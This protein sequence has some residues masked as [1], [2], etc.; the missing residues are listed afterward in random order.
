MSRPLSLGVLRGDPTES[1]TC[2]LWHCERVRQHTDW[3]R[4]YLVGPALKASLDGS[5]TADTLLAALGVV[6]NQAR[7]LQQIVQEAG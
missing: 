7:A 5:F 6:E 1:V 3:L 2:A 4:K